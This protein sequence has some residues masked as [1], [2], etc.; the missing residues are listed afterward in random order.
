LALHGKRRKREAAELLT[1]M[2]LATRG[3]NKEIKRALQKWLAG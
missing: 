2:Q 3:D 1:V